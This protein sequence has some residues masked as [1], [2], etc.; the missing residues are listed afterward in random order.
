MLLVFRSALGFFQ[1]IIQ[2]VH[3]IHEDNFIGL[4]VAPKRHL[5]IRI[6]LIQRPGD[7][8]SVR[9]ASG[10]V[11]SGTLLQLTDEGFLKIRENGKERVITGGDVIES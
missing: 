5:K 6:R 1:R 11:V 10:E 4:T 9:L 2:A 3:Q 7:T 8:V